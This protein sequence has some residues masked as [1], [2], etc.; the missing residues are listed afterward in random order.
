M[1]RIEKLVREIKKD[2]NVSKENFSGRLINTTGEIYEKYGYGATKLYLIDK[3]K[4][5]KRS[6]EAKILLRV[7]EKVEDARLP[8]SLGGF[9]I[10][11]LNAVK[12]S[13]EMLK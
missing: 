2:R 13:E 8:S 4:D 7:V 12:K 5:K 10:R 3:I 6:Y 9:I 1:D 11:K